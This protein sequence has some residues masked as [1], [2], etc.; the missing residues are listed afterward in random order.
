MRPHAPG[1]STCASCVGCER[2]KLLYDIYHMQIMEGDLIA[3]IREYAPYIAH[4]H[5]GGVPGR[6]EI[7]QTQEIYYP[8]VMK[9]ILA[10]GFQRFCRPGIPSRGSTRSPRCGRRSRSATW[11]RNAAVAAP[12]KGTVPFSSGQASLAARNRDRPQ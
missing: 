3:T 8:A 7:D 4:Y 2:F 11:I 1:A 10:T 9:A 6:H 12:P 5:T